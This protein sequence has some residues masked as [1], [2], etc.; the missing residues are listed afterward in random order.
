MENDLEKFQIQPKPFQSEF[1]K[2]DVRYPAFVAAWGTGKTLFAILRGLRLSTIP[3]NLGLIVRKE[4]TDLRDS[5]IRDF[6][7][8]TGLKVGSDKDVTLPNG[9][10]IMFRHGKE[11]D[12]LKNIKLGWF[13]MEQAEEFDTDEQFQY[14]RGRLRRPVA[15]HC[16]MVIAN[17]KGH[18]WIWRLWK[19]NPPSGEY[20]LWE[21]T[22]FQNAENLPASYIK[23]LETMQ[24]ESP[25]HYNRFISNSWDELEEGDI[26]IQYSDII[27]SQKVNIIQPFTKKII[28]LDPAE[29]GDDESVI[30]ALE[31][32]RVVGEDIFCQKQPMETVGRTIA[33]KRKFDGNLIVGDA[34]GIGSGIFS[35][36]SE[37]GERVLALK[38]SEKDSVSD[39]AKFFNLRAEI[40]WWAREQFQERLPK[41]FEEQLIAQLSAIK[42]QRNS[43]GQI[44][45]EKK[46]EIKK[47]IGK[48][49]DRSDAYVMG[50]WGLKFATPKEKEV[51]IDA[52]REKKEVGDYMAV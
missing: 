41:V 8:Y 12:V 31:N 47:R 3:N 10:V 16:G 34:I 38:V 1:L 33:M 7:E 25:V 26:V 48:S 15:L 49:P 2:T 32:E 51:K 46:E 6:E 44:Q 5:T 30:Y 50:L 27:E 45:I 35:R 52:Y 42:H 43:F 21:A 4:F 13:L 14:L 19:A 17:V 40:Y 18:N 23:D 37:M 29:M 28:A 39:K 9:A 20:K 11:L 22:T 24:E 36:L